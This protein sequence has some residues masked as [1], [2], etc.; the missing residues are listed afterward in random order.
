MA[1][2]AKKV[3]IASIA[4]QAGVSLATVSRVL[5]NYPDVSES[6]RK[7][8]LAV[9]EESQFIPDKS[10][11]RTLR[12]S[13]IIGVGDITD[14]IATILTGMGLAAN[15][16]GI[17][18]SI[19]RCTGKLSLL[20]SCR[21]WRSD[22]VAMICCDSLQDEIPAL[23]AAKLPC[24][25]VNQRHEGDLVG[26]VDNNSCFGTLQLLKHLQSQGHRRI[27]YLCGDPPNGKYQERINIYQEFMASIGE[28]D[29]E[30][31]VPPYP[32]GHVDGLG[33]DKKAGYQQ[34]LQ[35][36]ANVSGVTALIC[37]NDEIAFGCYKACYDSNLRIPDD[38]SIVGCDNQSFAKYLMPGLTTIRVPLTNMGRR[39]IHSLGDFLRGKITEL[40]KEQ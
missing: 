38:I 7:R 10:L 6:L 37:A 31:L 33:R 18:L 13:V 21:V 36:L 11:E 17:E 27:A 2:K 26:Y 30:L 19:Q 9:I 40:P 15:M 29:P 8:V 16:E 1:R 39:V 35:L 3:N 12:V 24:M 23:T 4:E 22:A 32:I 14:Y 5:N 25:L 20:R 34:V 28:A